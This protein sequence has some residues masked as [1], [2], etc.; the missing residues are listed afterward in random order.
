V[1]DP[2]TRP[3][4]LPGRTVHDQIGNKLGEVT[5]LYAPSGTSDPAWVTVEISQGLVAS[6]TVFVP[7]AR[8]KEEGGELLVPYSSKHLHDAP[9]VSDGRQLTA[10][11]DARLRG[12][13]GLDRDDQ[14]GK[15]NPDSYAARV[16][17]SDEPAQPIEADEAGGGGD[18]DEGDSEAASPEPGD[19]PLVGREV[20]GLRGQKI[21]KI[22]RLL[23]GRDSRWAIVD[24]GVLGRHTVVVPLDYAEERD[25]H[26]F[27]PYEAD[28]AHAA[29]HIELEDGNLTDTAM[30]HLAAHFGLEHRSAPSGISEEEAADLSRE[31]REATPPGMDDGPDNPVTQ[32][33]HERAQELG[34]P[35]AEDDTGP[36]AGDS[37]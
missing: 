35:G 33:R 31:P 5:G 37:G 7:L 29:S 28:H 26:V 18:E 15:D 32:R 12:H 9:E 8:V 36:D 16:P 4:E 1:A 19:D 2:I 21:G 20:R 34:I 11:D 30:E 6:R 22:D 14:V 25:D 27:V 17:D 24:Y 13:Y 3:G 23:A 10:E